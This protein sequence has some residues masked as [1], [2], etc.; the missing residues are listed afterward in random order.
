M[1]HC[2]PDQVASRRATR[3]SV[4]PGKG[5]ERKGKVR[6]G[7]GEQSKEGYGRRGMSA[8]PKVDGHVGERGREK[9]EIEER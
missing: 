2:T 6:R 9:W 4:H 7:N 5:D 1:A 8:R 3:A